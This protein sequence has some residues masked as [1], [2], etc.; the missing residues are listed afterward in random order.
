MAG[1]ATLAI[2]AFS[3]SA[4]PTRAPHWLVWN[5]KTH[6]AT[7]TLIAGYNNN[8]GGFNFNG[9]G[10]GKMTITV[11]N[12]AHVNVVF[13]N[14]SALPHSALF[15]PLNK[16]NSTGRYPLAFKGATSPNATNGV[17]K[18]KTQKFSFVANKAGSYALVCA[19]PGHE[20]AGM[21]DTFVVA[22]K[23]NASIAFKK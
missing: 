9:Y 5:A 14:D 17:A 2:P 11:P 21:W 6:T 3:A 12:G 1:A 13:S 4:A 16:R 20:A 18:G 10:N 22:K 7:L 23:G 8:I 19:V 15:T